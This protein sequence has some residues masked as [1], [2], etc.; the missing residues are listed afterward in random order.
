[1]KLGTKIVLGLLITKILPLWSSLQ[2][3]E[4]SKIVADG[5]G[6]WTDWWNSENLR[7]TDTDTVLYHFPF[8]SV[9][10]TGS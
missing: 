5:P 4:L 3:C 6:W 8:A 1:M 2:T 10:L 7:I 9:I